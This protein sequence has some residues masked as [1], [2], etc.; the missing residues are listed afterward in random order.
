MK[1][2]ILISLLVISTIVFV[3]WNSSETKNVSRYQVI[4][5]SSISGLTWDVERKLKEGWTL[6]GGVSFGDGSYIQAVSK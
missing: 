2:I 3:A 6:A 5:L 1:K 4:Y